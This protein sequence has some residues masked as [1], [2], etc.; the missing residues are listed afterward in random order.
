IL[1]PGGTVVVTTPNQLSALSV[2]SLVVKHQFVAFQDAH[3]PTHRTA[4]LESDLH[5][6]ATESGLDPLE[7]AYSLCGRIPLTSRHYPSA[8]AGVFPRRLSD[9]VMLI[10]RKTNA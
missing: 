7:I 9:N 5:R 2:L 3:F 6:A 4:L 1:R 10:A 8:L